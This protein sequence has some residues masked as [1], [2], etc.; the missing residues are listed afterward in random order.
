[1]NKIK[2][3]K[4]LGIFGLTTL[5]GLVGSPEVMAIV[6]QY[7]QSVITGFGILGMVLRLITTSPIL[8][9]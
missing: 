1:M 5:T 8:K 9:K 7:P 2:G 6:S 3:W 4:T